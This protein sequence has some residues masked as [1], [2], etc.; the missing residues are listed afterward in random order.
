MCT[1]DRNNPILA[2]IDAVIETIYIERCSKSI[3]LLSNIIKY[4]ILKEKKM[5]ENLGRPYRKLTD[6]H[7]YRFIINNNSKMHYQKRE[8]NK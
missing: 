4:I 8:N 6:S 1:R 3:L 5:E 7:L 2:V